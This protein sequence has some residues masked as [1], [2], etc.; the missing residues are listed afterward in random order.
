[1]KVK[2]SARGILGVSS[3]AEQ[4]TK[5]Q[6]STDVPTHEAL[7]PQIHIRIEFSHEIC[8]FFV[9]PL[10]PNLCRVW[11]IMHSAGLTFLVPGGYM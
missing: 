8:P 6:V 1:M 5:Q 2:G 10:T 3:S 4:M 9:W 11:E 7:I